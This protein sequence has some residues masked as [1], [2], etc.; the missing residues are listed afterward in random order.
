MDL[1]HLV[2]IDAGG[3]RTRALAAL[4]NGVFSRSEAGAGNFQLLGLEG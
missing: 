3:T 1:H 2:G 4:E